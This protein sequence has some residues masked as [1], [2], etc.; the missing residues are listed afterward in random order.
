MLSRGTVAGPNLATCNC[1]LILWRIMQPMKIEL[2]KP[3]VNVI[4]Y[5]PRKVHSST[6]GAYKSIYQYSNVMW[7]PITI[8]GDFV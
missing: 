8:A 7:L 2:V 5:F 6:T 1:S 3:F 4:T